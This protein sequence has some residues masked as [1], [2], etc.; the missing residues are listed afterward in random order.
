MSNLISTA[1][2]L[3]AGLLIGTFF[4]FGL[5]WTVRRAVASR[6]PARWLIGSMLLRFGVA[7]GAFCLIGSSHWLAWVLCLAGFVLARVMLQ[8]LTGLAGQEPDS[9]TAKSHY[10]P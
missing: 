8:W 7:L 2:P 3:L 9:A 6:R 1:L 10:A 5:W 4:F